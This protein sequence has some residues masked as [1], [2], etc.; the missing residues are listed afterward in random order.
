[1]TDLLVGV[2]LG[3]SSVALLSFLYGFIST[4][5]KDKNK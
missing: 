5:V 1:M 2:V 3:V 4:W